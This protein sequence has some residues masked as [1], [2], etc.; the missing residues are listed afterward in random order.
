VLVMK[1][2]L[3]PSEANAIHDAAPEAEFQL[4]VA[5]LARK[6]VVSAADLSTAVSPA[7][8]VAA[9]AVAPAEKAS[10][11]T[12]QSSAEPAKPPTPPK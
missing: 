5:A 6:G 3:A 10:L 4:L 12:T 11:Q 7:T 9:A 1:G 2:V 8:A